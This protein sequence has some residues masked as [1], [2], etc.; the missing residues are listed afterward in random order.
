MLLILICR[1]KTVFPVLAKAVVSTAE[2]SISHPGH[3]PVLR[4]TGP[5]EGGIHRPYTTDFAF[6]E[7]KFSGNLIRISTSFVINLFEE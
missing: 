7:S 2:G 5:T 1:Q 6:R 4:D 3:D